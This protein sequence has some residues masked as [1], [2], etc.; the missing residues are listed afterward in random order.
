MAQ[1]E[2]M[3]VPLSVIQAINLAGLCGMQ[4][5]RWRCING[6]LSDFSHYRLNIA[7]EQV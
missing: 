6:Y 2:D 4:R 5:R 7:R 3:P 1:T